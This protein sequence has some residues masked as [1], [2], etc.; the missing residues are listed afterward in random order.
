MARLLE[1]PS[2][3]IRQRLVFLEL[4]AVESGSMT[5]SQASV[6]QNLVVAV[7]EGAFTGLWWR[8]PLRL[9]RLSS[10]SMAARAM[11]SAVMGERRDDTTP[12]A[13]LTVVSD[14]KSATEYKYDLGA[15]L[16]KEKKRL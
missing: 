13:M 12:S 6:Q 9:R 5:H 3:R 14:S 16:I 7:D 10:P 4:Q 2:G 1:A 11:V 15:V 8:H